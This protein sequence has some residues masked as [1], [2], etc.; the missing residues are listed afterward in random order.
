MGDRRGM[1][2]RSPVWGL[3][4]AQLSFAQ[5]LGQS[6][7][8]VAPSAVMVTLPALVMPA[9]G[10]ATLGVFVVTALLMT[11]VGYCAAQFSTRMVAV[12]GVY[13]YTVKGL[14]PIPGIAAGWSVIIGYAGAAMASTLGAAG[15]LTALLSRL[16]VPDNPVTTTLLAVLVGVVALALMVRGVRLSARIMLTVEVFA[17]VAASAVLIIAFTGSVTGGHDPPKMAVTEPHSALGFAML[18]AITSYVGFESAGTV[19]R[20]AQ[21]PFVTVTRAIRWT[22]L[23]L[24]VLY[25]FAAAMQSAGGITAGL[26]SIPI[27]RMPES[28]G[29]GSTALSIVMELGITA[30]WFACV[31]GSTT[32]LSRTLFAM[33]REGVV[34]HRIGHAHQV[35]RTPHIALCAAIPLIVAVPIGYLLISGSTREVLI[36]LLAV[37]AHGYIGA[38][39][40]VCLATPA[41]LRR[42]GELTATP[43]FVGLAAA[44][45]MT[46]IITWAAFTVESPVW[47]ATA[48]YAGL[49]ATGFGVF[50][51]RR[52]MIPDLAHRVGVFDETVA[53]DVFADYNPWEV[54][55]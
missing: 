34:S 37:S 14:G 25:T 30:S 3:R 23:A 36:G 2:S 42:I 55:R 39:L 21:R 54:R 41:F 12:S 46:A 7:S 19:A 29:A 1:R 44:A 53:G 51:L 11:A 40:L 26:G 20:E 13:S 4:R 27:V 10:R 52:R 28:A 8:A 45:M 47:I 35:F 17:I 22:P 43:V 15:Y 32:A 5:V 18:L 33:G 9:A 50:A 48:V 6:V 31:I 24:G 38:Y 16:G 49:L